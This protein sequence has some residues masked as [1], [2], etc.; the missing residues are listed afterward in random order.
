[1]KSFCDSLKKDS[2]PASQFSDK[3]VALSVLRDEFKSQGGV[4]NSCV[5]SPYNDTA[6]RRAGN[7]WRSIAPEKG[8]GTTDLVQKESPTGF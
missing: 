5:S 4:I 2:F 7:F 8:P 6:E 1:M 3:R